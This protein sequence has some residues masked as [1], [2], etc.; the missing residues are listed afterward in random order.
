MTASLNELQRTIDYNFKDVSR[1]ENAVTHRSKGSNNNERL[2]FLGDAILGFVVADILY[3]KF[4]QASEGQLSR[5][6]ASL[7]KKETL[8]AL[9]RELSLGDF[10][11]LGSGE[12]K[13]GGFRRDSILAD[14]LEAVIGAIYLDG[15]IE[16]AC[17]LIKRCLKD[18]LDS[19]SLEGADTKDPKTC[20]QE[21]LQGRR[22]ALPK[23]E[24]VATFGDEHNQ[25]FEVSCIVA[26]LDEPV[27]GSGASRRKAEQ[28]AAQQALDRLEG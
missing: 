28:A 25:S 20:L 7:V 14:A 11:L 10:L 8:A 21:Y 12:L 17:S 23:Y 13:S 26:G 22:L 15:G 5:F 2:E 4:G 18:R 6:R 27:K 24:V 19:L 1:L 16:S 3:S 9:A